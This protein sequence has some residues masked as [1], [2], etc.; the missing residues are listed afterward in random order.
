[1]LPLVNWVAHNLIITTIELIESLYL[2][3]SPDSFQMS[4]SGCFQCLFP[5]FVL[6][7]RYLL[8]EQVTQSALGET[9][10]LCRTISY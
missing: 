6:F 9:G 3:A 4:S 8:G 7:Y 2:N 1:M 5:V 10:T